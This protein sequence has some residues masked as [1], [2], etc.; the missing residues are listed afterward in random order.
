MPYKSDTQPRR[1]GRQS[2]GN[3]ADQAAAADQDPATTTAQR[4]RPGAGREG[5]PAT[6]KPAKRKKNRNR[7][8]CNRR[9]SFISPEDTQLGRAAVPV[10][11]APTVGNLAADRP[12]PEAAQP[13]YKLGRDLSE[14][15]LESEALLDHRYV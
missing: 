11:D 14:T 12:K 5:Q 8:R 7:K 15:S 9:Q 1:G 6:G 10:P 13:F 4:N 2:G 3:R